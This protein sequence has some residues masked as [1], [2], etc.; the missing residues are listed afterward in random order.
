MIHADDLV[1]ASGKLVKRAPG[2]RG[3]YT[4]RISDYQKVIGISAKRP[5]AIPKRSLW[6]N[7]ELVIANFISKIRKKQI[8]K[9]NWHFFD[10]K[11]FKP[12]QVPRI[13]YSSRGVSARIAKSGSSTDHYSLLVLCNA[14][15]GMKSIQLV[16]NEQGNSFTPVLAILHNFYEQS[17]VMESISRSLTNLLRSI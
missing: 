1:H 13:S 16:K 2:Q 17:K 7:R 8:G 10:E 11:P 9:N 6:I 15:Y 12:N 14:E 5:R 4:Q 3:V